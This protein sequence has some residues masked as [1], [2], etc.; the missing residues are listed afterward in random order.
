MLSQKAD[1]YTNTV[2]RTG[3][4]ACGESVS[5]HN[6]SELVVLFSLK[7]E[8]PASIGRGYVHIVNLLSS[9]C[10]AVAISAKEAAAMRISCKDSSWVW[11]SLLSLFIP[12]AFSLR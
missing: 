10:N 8:A 9:V 12:S 1:K 3:I 6:S 5:R 7:Q 2:G 11:L 4:Y